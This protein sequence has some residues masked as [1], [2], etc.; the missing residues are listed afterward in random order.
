[1]PGVKNGE[2]PY[3]AT[4]KPEIPGPIFGLFF[5]VLVP[6]EASVWSVDNNNPPT[7]TTPPTRLM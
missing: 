1:M 6:G 3:L 2:R 4:P 7:N 5:A